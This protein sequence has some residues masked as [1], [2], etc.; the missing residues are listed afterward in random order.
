[1]HSD[2]LYDQDIPI[3][4][5]FAYLSFIPPLRV[6]VWDMSESK[7]EME[8]K[9]GERMAERLAGTDEEVGKQLELYSSR[10][11]TWGHCTGNMSRH[12]PSMLLLLLRRRRQQ[13]MSLIGLRRSLAVGQ[14]LSPRLPPFHLRPGSRLPYP[15]PSSLLRRRLCQ[16]IPVKKF[17]FF[18]ISQFSFLMQ[19]KSCSFF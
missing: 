19:P 12:H 13:T 18:R 3:L 10:E 11:K 7:A 4:C 1:M 6:F 8:G 15:E 16:P 2:E 14:R 5:S 9:L 17:L